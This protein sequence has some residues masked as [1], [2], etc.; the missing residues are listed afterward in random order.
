VIICHRLHEHNFGAN[1]LSNL[2]DLELSEMGCLYLDLAAGYC[3]D[4]LLGRLNALSDFMVGTMAKRLKLKSRLQG[5][6]LVRKGMLKK[7][8]TI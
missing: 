1:F 8:Q 7:T 3:D 2:F 6:T 4:T 5:E